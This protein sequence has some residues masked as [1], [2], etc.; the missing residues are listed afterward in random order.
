MDSR[1]ITSLRTGAA[2]A[3]AAKYL[4]RL[5]FANHHYLWLRKSRTCSAQGTLPRPP[6]SNLLSL[7][8]RT[9]SKRC[10]LRV[11]SHWTWI[12]VTAVADLAAAVRQSDICVTCTPSRQPLLG[13]D[14]VSPGTFIAAV[15]ADD[16]EKQE[17]HPSLMAKQARSY[18]TSSNSVR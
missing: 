15:G 8:T 3:V 17:L 18:A 14:D 6:V 5:R 10:G 4:A 9:E 1:D 16:P 13:S 12:P 7:T 2:T 11:I